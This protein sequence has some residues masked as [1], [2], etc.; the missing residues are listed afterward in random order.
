M[1]REWSPL[2]EA[3]ERLTIP[4]LWERLGLPGQARRYGRSPFR[5]DRSPSFSVYAEGRRW[6][7]FATGSG[8]DAA[9]FLACALDVPSSEGVRRLIA[10][11]G[12][13]QDGRALRSPDRSI[14]TFENT[15]GPQGAPAGTGPGSTKGTAEQAERAVKRARWPVMEPCTEADIAV[16]AERR[17]LAPEA[18]ALAARR[19][20]LWMAD[21]REGRAWVLTDSRRVSAQARRLDGLP[22]ESLGGAKARTLPGSEAS[23]PLGLAEAAAYPAIALVE[24][25]PDLLAACH[26]LAKSGVADLVAPVAMLGAGMSIQD[27]AVPLFAGKRVRIFAHPDAAGQEGARRWYRQLRRSARHVDG[28]TPTVG[29]LNDFVCRE[30]EDL[31]AAW[32]FTKGLPPRRESPEEAE[33]RRVAGELA[34]MQ[35]AGAITGPDDPEA[36]L[37]AAVIRLF[38]ARFDDRMAV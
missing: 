26:L 3:K 7:D 19:G 20:L 34:R 21:S 1:K 8:G 25:G 22:W 10:M 13:G 29:D 14:R 6:R 16:I 12:T 36:P 23:W 35:R 17:R 5:E 9:D 2:E 27:Q 4:M 38:G 28:F 32:S 33:S 11:A 18:V 15:P 30:G 37:C 24:G 31:A